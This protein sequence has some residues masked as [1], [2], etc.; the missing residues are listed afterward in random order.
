MIEVEQLSAWYSPSKLALD[1][2]TFRA[3]RGEVVGLLGG[4]GAGKTT[5]LRIL[6]GLL[7]PQRGA[8]RVAGFDLR[9]QAAQARQSLGYLPEEAVVD[10]EF[11][12]HEYLALRA[13]LKGLPARMR[14]QRVDDVTAQVG[15]QDQ[16]RALIGHLSKGYR[17]RVGLADALL[18]QPQVL[19]LDEPTDGLDPPQRAQTLRLIA[20]L[21]RHHT[22]L[23][24]T[25]VL[26]EAE[27]ICHRV[28]LLDAG[29][30]VAAGSP[31]ELAA[32]VAT[33]SH[34]LLRCEGNL[35]ELQAALAHVE[36]VAAVQ[37]PESAKPD[38]KS[39]PRAN[40][41]HTL[42]VELTTS[43]DS[44]AADRIARA[45]LAIGRLH[46]L[47]PQR[48]SLDALFQILTRSS[49]DSTSLNQ[50]VQADAS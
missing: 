20:D 24:S 6:A 46:E 41:S 40:R 28:L 33:S 19:L 23:L 17:Q 34:L 12:V 26:P 18:A 15:L 9:T 30:L 7:H 50:G 4:N 13:D 10:N 16:R 3:H 14:R 42:L 37:V 45:V 27:S 49:V 21:G 36:G 32:R 43:G 5:L 47:A 29:C 35:Q 22:V 31:G 8:A 39:D 44:H 1:A 48:R 25:H 11:R 38:A 2:I